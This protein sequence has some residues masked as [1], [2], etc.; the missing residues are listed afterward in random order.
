M[1]KD[2][3]IR[4]KWVDLGVFM[5]VFNV[6]FDIKEIHFQNRLLH[7]FLFTIAYILVGIFFGLLFYLEIKQKKILFINESNLNAGLIWGY[8]L[9]YNCF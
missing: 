9:F 6:L 3:N 8:T 2:G 4:L 1:R 5:T 7:P